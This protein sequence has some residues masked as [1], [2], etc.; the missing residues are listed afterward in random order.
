MLGRKCIDVT[1]FY[2]HTVDILEKA[3]LAKGK[4]LVSIG[5]DTWGCTFALMDPMDIGQIARIAF[6]SIG[7]KYK[8]ALDALQNASKIAIKKLYIVGGGSKNNFLNQYAA[9][10]LG[11]PV[12]AGP[13][14]ATVAGN[15][16][17][18]AY[19]CGE[20][21]GHEQIRN[22]VRDSFEIEEYHPNELSNASLDADRF[23]R[24]C[25]MKKE[26]DRECTRG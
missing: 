26:G 12:F 14:E 24:L 6:E 3:V 5:I 20:I 19:A 16:L 18:Q 1:G 13:V 15:L 9:D 4:E 21:C 22:I 8:M 2:R 7:M 10:I 17:M 23:R 11:I 25:G